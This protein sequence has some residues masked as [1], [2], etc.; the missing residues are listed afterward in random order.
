MESAMTAQVDVLQAAASRL[1]GYIDAVEDGQ[2]F[3]WAWDRLH[4]G[5]RL[6]IE[7]SAG[8]RMAAS[9]TADRPR[10]DLRA[11]GIGDGAHAFVAEAPGDDPVAEAV[12]P[13]TGERLVLKPRGPA[14]EAA[15]N[16]L[17]LRAVDALHQGQR[18]L[19]AVLREV[20]PEAEQM[21]KALADIRDAQSAIEKQQA[22]LEIFLL[23]FETLL[24]SLAATQTETQTQPRGFLARLLR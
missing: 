16:A 4:P 22:T 11:G 8:G 1:E 17:L 20:R 24:R 21:A 5:D 18:R 23:R 3:G 7:I 13:T 10:P 6:A 14:D 12:S 2:V 15:G 9:V 19:G